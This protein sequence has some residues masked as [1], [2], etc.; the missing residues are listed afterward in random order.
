[1]PHLS[2]ALKPSGHQLKKNKK[3]KTKVEI[4]KVNAV[5]LHCAHNAQIRLGIAVTTN[6]Q[7]LKLLISL[8]CV[9]IL[10]A[11]IECY[12]LVIVF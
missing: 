4:A 3:Q 7:W 9:N 6:C 12:S 11:M 5:Q 1:M 2:G 10:S 8:R